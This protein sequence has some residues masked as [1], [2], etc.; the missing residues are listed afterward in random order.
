M[1]FKRFSLRHSLGEFPEPKCFSLAK[2]RRAL[3][4]VVGFAAVFAG[5]LHGV[6][7]L[8]WVYDQ[9][10][11]GLATIGLI[12]AYCELSIFSQENVGVQGVKHSAGVLHEDY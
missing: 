7:P 12:V 2:A 6:C 8:L 9:V 1:L 4:G 11:E 10:V 5:F 3:R